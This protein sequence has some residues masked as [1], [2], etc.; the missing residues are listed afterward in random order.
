MTSKSKAAQPSLFPTDWITGNV[1]YVGEKSSR[2][3]A[4]RASKETTSLSIW[5]TSWA[6]GNS[7]VKPEKSGKKKSSKSKQVR[8]RKPS[9]TPAKTDP[10]TNDNFLAG[11]LDTI[12][13]PFGTE[14]FAME[15]EKQPKQPKQ[16][17]LPASSFFSRNVSRR[18]SSST[19]SGSIKGSQEKVVTDPSKPK[20][21]LK[22]KP[23]PVHLRSGRPSIY[24]EAM[25]MLTLALLIYTFADLRK[26][27]RE[28]E[29]QSDE[30]L[31][32]PIAIA[33]VIEAIH[34]HKG[35][36]QR[37]ARGT[38][39]DD[40]AS[41]LQAL[42]DIQSQ[43]KGASSILGGIFCKKASASSELVLTHFHDE[44]STQGMVYGITVNH[45]KRRVSVVFRGSVTQ[46][47]FV[48]DAK[49][50]QKK[51]PNPV[52]SSA[53]TDTINIHTGFYQYLFQKDDDGKIRLDHILE[54]VKLLLKKHHGYTVFF[55]GH[56]LGGALAT[57]CGFYAAAR[58]KP[59]TKGPVVVYSI[60][61]PRVG[62]IDFRTA[63]QLLERQQRLQHLRISNKED[64]VTLLP[65]MTTFLGAPSSILPTA[66]TNLNGAINLY[67]HCGIHLR[68]K[69]GASS[70]TI[71]ND[72]TGDDNQR[73]LYSISYAKDKTGGDEDDGDQ[74]IHPSDE[75]RRSL[76][77]AM[78]LVETV[79]CTRADYS[80]WAGYHSCDE[81]ERRLVTS[82]QHF[83]EVTLDHLYADEALVGG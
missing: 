25:E 64:V 79:I 28:G 41:R 43:Q 40:L 37:R 35:A 16:P 44:K 82:K 48:T 13:S 9:K 80:K 50:A 62:N 58:A 27:A 5:D 26:M 31:Q 36:L 34:T 66:N 47:D 69:P 73:R 71:Q 67:K 65:F 51:V 55:T 39:H 29:I 30:L 7:S 83:T 18:I 54:D 49:Y 23:K 12:S 32:H 17:D 52:I 60:A 70:P 75:L 59:L 53:A 4:K 45:I 20:P 76:V 77:A 19:K 22:A 57:L 24:E 1:S 33:H 78:S 21:S 10:P 8:L 38:D 72:S 61:S 81:Y 15:K 2:G 46:Q 42:Q 11:V 14:I 63:F 74:G 56:S 3:P 6:V 68:L